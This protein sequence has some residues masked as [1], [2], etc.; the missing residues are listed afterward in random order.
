[1]GKYAKSKKE[2]APKPT[3]TNKMGEQAFKMSPK[4]ELVSV[5]MTTFMTDA[6]YEKEDAMCNRMKGLVDKLDPKFT[7]QLAIYARNEG[8][9][10]SVT[11]FLAAYAARYLSAKEY[12]KRF[13]QKIVIRPDDIV[14]ILCCYAALNPKSKKVNNNGISRFRNI[15]NA[16][17][18]GFRAAMENFD[19]YQLDK[20]KM[21][22]REIH[23]VDLFNLFSPRPQQKNAE[24]YRRLINGESLS[25]LYTSKVLEKE[26]SKAGQVVA[27]SNDEK[28]QAME[29]AIAS[30]LSNP[31][32]MPMMNLVRNLRNIILNAPQWVDEA[33][34]QLRN[35][36]KVLKSRML[37]FRF[38]SAYQ[39]V[40]KLTVEEKKASSLKITFES[41]V[42]KKTVDAETLAILKKKVLAALEDSVEIAN[43][44][45]PILSG[46]CA[47]LMDHS[48]SVRGDRGGSSKV[49]AMSNVTTAQIG[50]LFASMVAH[51]QPNVYVGLFGDRL[52]DVPMRRDMGILEFNKHSYDLG[53]RCGGGTET[54]IYEFMRRAI[55]D[56][57]HI[58]NVIVFSD[59]EIGTQYTKSK[60]HSWRMGGDVFTPRYGCD[61]RDV[62]TH[63]QDLWKEFKK[64]NPACNWIVVN[65]K[66]SSGTNVFAP[67]ERILNIAGWSEN[68]FS[69]I[70][71]QCKGWDA[72]IKEIESIEI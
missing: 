57:T 34:K 32:G 28:Q 4:A 62:G 60:T 52:I 37:P 67:D 72:I 6:Y 19:A 23:M 2:A 43:E 51:R 71:S 69:I 64:I 1:M 41:D 49:S 12:S 10:R 61:S 50:N 27:K 65:L 29:E 30:V 3:E 56:K 38:I 25:D 36:D 21:E 14:E 39:E 40:E 55:R 47:I 15:P 16:M 8:K 70:T 48:G 63:F 59:C 44:N 33:C 45:I 9:L 22:R 18:K 66:S 58:D 26:M 53:E 11:H 68:I 24:A 35:R 54:G 42:Q 31:Q 17:K 5:A 13:Y 20:Y 46:N 7:A